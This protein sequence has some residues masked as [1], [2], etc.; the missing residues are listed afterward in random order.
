MHYWYSPDCGVVVFAEPNANTD[1]EKYLNSQIQSGQDAKGNQL[2]ENTQWIDLTSMSYT[3][4]VQMNTI[5]EGGTYYTGVTNSTS[6]A[7]ASGYAEKYIAGEQFPPEVK[8]G[9]M[10]IYNGYVYRYNYYYNVTSSSTYAYLNENQN[11]WGVKVQNTSKSSYP[12]MLDMVNKQPVTTLYRTF[13]SCKNMTTAP[14]ISKY[15]RELNRTFYNCNSLTNIDNVQITINA[16]NLHSTFS[17]TAISRLPNLSKATNIEDMSF[18]FYE[19]LNITSVENLKMPNSTTVATRIFYK[20]KNL[21]NINGLTLSNNLTTAYEMFGGTSIGNVDNFI[22]PES[23]TNIERLFCQVKTLS[24]KITI[25]S[26]PTSY[27]ACFSECDMNNIV[28]EGKCDQALKQKI[29]NTHKTKVT[30]ITW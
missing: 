15:A 9:D 24:G 23:V 17:K 2:D 14:H 26:N 25:N 28:I 30:T 3:L 27:S 10:Y 1:V 20:C 12:D 13:E 22:I 4:P 11:G 6:W 18:A 21:T 19:C 5:P 29:I 16:E 8:T 7:S